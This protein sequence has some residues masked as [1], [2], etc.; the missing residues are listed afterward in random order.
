M[1]C[2]ERKLQGVKKIQGKIFDLENDIIGLKALLE[3][4]G[5]KDQVAAYHKQYQED[6]RELQ[7]LR[8]R[9]AEEEKHILTLWMQ[10][11][12]L[13]EAKVKGSPTPSEVENLPMPTEVEA[14]QIQLE[15]ERERSFQLSVQLEEVKRKEL[16]AKIEAERKRV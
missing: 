13:K 1:R 2:K 16:A 3:A 8:Y 9:L 7:K 5:K 11:T 4:V 14:L 12:Q 10:L 15:K 6:Q